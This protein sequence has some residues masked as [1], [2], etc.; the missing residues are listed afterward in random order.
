M[1]NPGHRVK[2]L[3]L[4]VSLRLVTYLYSERLLN[5]DQYL[6]WIISSLR[7]CDLDSISVW[8]LVAQ[9]NWKEI[10]RYRQRGKPLTEAILKQLSKVGYVQQ[11]LQ[12]QVNHRIQASESANGDT[13]GSLSEK[14]V[15]LLVSIMTFSPACFILPLCWSQYESMIRS[16]LEKVNVEMMPNFKRL[17]QRNVQLQR[18]VISD[19]YSSQHVEQ[20]KI[21]AILDEL[22]PQADLSTLAR[23]WLAKFKDRNLFIS[24]CLCWATS[25]SRNG[26]YRIYIAIRL[27]R[28][29]A[30]LHVEVEE[31]L[32][33]FLAIHVIMPPLQKVHVYKVLAELVHSKTISV[34]KYLQRLMAKG[35][36]AGCK[37]RDGVR[38]FSAHAQGLLANGCSCSRRMCSGF[39]SFL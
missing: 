26:S 34:S 7:N 27:F 3:I 16:S 39:S 11:S 24:T 4:M 12:R 14:L 8:L 35:S 32:L 25:P 17:C 28:L 9:I 22:P 33:D 37:N 38:T 21:I 15:R 36:L 29:W 5:Q 30:K 13:F 18:S 31:P 2:I 10:L 20:Q 19:V 1:L 23:V 6:E